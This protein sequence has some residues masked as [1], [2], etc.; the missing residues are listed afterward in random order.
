MPRPKDVNVN[1]TI[2]FELWYT[3]DSTTNLKSS[4]D[5]EAE[6]I[7]VSRSC[8]RIIWIKSRFKDY[9]VS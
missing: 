9:D 8:S 5:T 4:Y 6:Y 7:V 1:G 2:K 3:H